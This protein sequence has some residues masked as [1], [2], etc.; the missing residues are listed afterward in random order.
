MP[1]SSKFLDLFVL[2]FKV[3]KKR[4]CKLKLKNESI[5]FSN[6]L[7]IGKIVS[8]QNSGKHKFCP[9]PPLRNQVLATLLVGLK[10]ID[11]QLFSTIRVT[12][13]AFRN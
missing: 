13:N 2:Y 5:V 10:P 8:L 4:K 11:K 7:E 9:F 6:A 12:C 1:P 3:L